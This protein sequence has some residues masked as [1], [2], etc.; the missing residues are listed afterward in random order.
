MGTINSK[1]SK[2]KKNSITKKKNK[3]SNNNNNPNPNQEANKSS[4]LNNLNSSNNHINDNNSCA[5]EIV[6]LNNSSN[7]PLS[8]NTN[9]I[10]NNNIEK[11]NSQMDAL[12]SMSD[13][14]EKQR[15]S[16]NSITNRNNI[17]SS[18]N[19]VF[20]ENN[21]NCQII[22]FNNMSIATTGIP[23]VNLKQINSELTDSPMI[24]ILNT[25]NSSNIDGTNVCVNIIKP[26]F[27]NDSLNQKTKRNQLIKMKGVRFSEEVH[28]INPSEF[29]HSESHD[30]SSGSGGVS[31]GSVKIQNSTKNDSISSARVFSLIRM[32]RM[33]H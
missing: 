4:D 32:R 28:T 1:A 11:N 24:N 21:N 16:S 18:L 14:I 30:G 5:K 2:K 15:E 13:A 33:T 3:N 27:N 17:N 20:K 19:E 31:G 29:R 6:V 8:P 22:E 25:T 9:H 26:I 7:N 10:N 12:T 23:N